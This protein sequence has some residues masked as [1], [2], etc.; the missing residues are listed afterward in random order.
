MSLVKAEK[1]HG[2]RGYAHWYAHYL[3][4]WADTDYATTLR[5]WLKI[6]VGISL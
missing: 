4:R 1:G 5:N 2:Y 6:L 3:H